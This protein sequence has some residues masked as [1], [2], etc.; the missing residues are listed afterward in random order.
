MYSVYIQHVTVITGCG[1]SRPF[2]LLLHVLLL[3]WSL[4]VLFAPEKSTLLAPYVTGELRIPTFVS[5]GWPPRSELSCRRRKCFAAI[6]RWYKRDV[7]LHVV[8]AKK[9]AV[10]SASEVFCGDSGGSN[11]SCC[12]RRKASCRARVCPFSVLE[13]VA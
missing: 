2:L 10:V 4:L 13:L 9:R 6:F 12:G 8:A 3:P 11:R 7:L 5:D 1:Y